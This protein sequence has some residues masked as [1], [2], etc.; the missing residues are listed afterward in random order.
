MKDERE[1]LDDARFTELDP[2]LLSTPFQ[3]QTNW[4]V[5]TGAACA[6][7]TTLIDMLAERGYQT[8]PEAARPLI[9]RELAK[10]RVLEEIYE[11]GDALAPAVADVQQ[12]VEH[13]LRAAD[14]AFLDR[15]LPDCLFFYRNFGL[16][17]NELLAECFR[18]RYASVFLLDRLDL[19]LDGA[20]IPDDTYTV[21]LD[22]WLYRDYSALGYHVIRVPVLPPQERLEFILERL[23]EQSLVVHAQEE[24]NQQCSLNARN[25]VCVTAPVREQLVGRLLQG[26]GA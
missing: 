2:D 22:E 13:G 7:K 10:G 9:E 20:R 5:L 19:Q 8:V 26:Y 1:T 12:R 16:D 25:A 17:P 15:G 18:H 14:V 6:G 3:V 24:A 4:H 21:L 23:A 11:N